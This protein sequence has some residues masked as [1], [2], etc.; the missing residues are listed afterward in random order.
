[1]WPRRRLCKKT[2]PARSPVSEL[3]DFAA[4]E[5]ATARR[6]NYLIT[7]PHPHSATSEDGQQ[8]RAPERLP[9][10][11]ILEAIAD[12]F[13][14]PDYKD[15]KSL[16]QSGG[17]MLDK[18]A[19]FKELHV[20][21][22]EGQVHE[23][24]H[25]AVAAQDKFRF[26]PVKRALLARHGLASNWSLHDGY[27]SAIR[28]C[29]WPSV[30]KPEASLDKNPLTWARGGAHPPL[31][32]CCHE[33]VTAPALKKR[34]ER[35]ERQAAEHGKKEPK[36]KELDLYSIIAEKGFRNT[37][38]DR[39]AHKQ[40]ILYV[41]N[42]CSKA[43]ME[44]CWTNRG[45]LPGLIDDVWQWETM[46][47]SLQEERKSRMD[48]LYS[49]NASKC[50]CG[51]RWT[52]VV[53]AS[54]AA[55]GIKVDELCN[56]VL[57]LLRVGRSPECPVLVLAGASG[58]EGKSFFL[59][60]LLT[61]FG[62]AQVFE[63]PVKGS[64]PLL[65]LL[66]SK[67]CFFD[68]WRF[69]TDVLPWSVQC[70]LYD[71]SNVPVN[72]PQNVQG[73]SGHTKYTGTSPIFVTTKL[74]DVQTLENAAAPNIATGE[75]GNADASMIYRRLKV[76]SFTVRMTKPSGALPYCARCFAQYVLERGA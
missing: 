61:M 39:T 45:R 58:G 46:S 69:Q 63:S 29:Y 21:D 9:K 64:F 13:E 57:H 51:G 73:Q 10:E 41:R 3:C 31:H 59:K 44:F 15:P 35:A 28:Y 24:V 18:V 55:N 50:V 38:D 68:D 2:P 42:H 14:K 66:D 74:S 7:I 32:E 49:A 34:R 16:R 43:M 48:V 4:Q 30:K 27:W 71:G 62:V 8:L 75:P 37:A 23:H 60:P 36:V 17:I 54:L 76:H 25:I 53:C 72:R 19:I 52:E 11:A 40:L 6:R 56:D 33:P 20:A 22:A 70:L 67:L 5:D 65:G 1:M 12:A 47:V 26:L